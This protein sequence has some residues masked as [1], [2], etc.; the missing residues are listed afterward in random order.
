[1]AK[2]Q[3]IAAGGPPGRPGRLLRPLAWVLVGLL[4]SQFLLGMVTNLYARLPAALPGLHGSLDT[5]LGAAARWALLHG[6]PVLKIHV[7]VGLAIGGCAITLA[8]LA[9]QARQ[10]WWR[11][12]ALLGLLLAAP[13]GLAGAAFLAYR[14]NNFYS[15][16]MAAGFLGALFAYWAG[17]F[18]AREPVRA[19]PGAGARR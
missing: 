2:Q 13:A 8:A 19:G 6:P 9:V 16:L 11:L 10:P 7:I 5:R 12:C 17:L 4:A 15:L 18:L 3:P 14:H 1:M